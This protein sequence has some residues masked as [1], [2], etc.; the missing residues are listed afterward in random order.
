[1]RYIVHVENSTTH[2]IF[3]LYNIKPMINREMITIRSTPT[4]TGT[5]ITTT[6]VPVEENRIK[7]N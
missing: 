5:T 3:F 4:I 6:E 1:M 2:L 7:I